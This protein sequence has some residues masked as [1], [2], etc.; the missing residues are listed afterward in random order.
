[1]FFYELVH[2]KLFF[3]CGTFSSQE[4]HLITAVFDSHFAS[5][6]AKRKMM[7]KRNI[8]Y[9]CVLTFLL[10]FAPPAITGFKKTSSLV[11]LLVSKEKHELC[12][13]NNCHLGK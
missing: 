4:N 6:Y 11:I 1:M 10:Q 8:L 5:F 2:G 12:V 13:N 3:T 7:K 9:F